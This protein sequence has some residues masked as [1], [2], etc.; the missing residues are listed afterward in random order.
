M[1]KLITMNAFYFYAIAIIGLL[2]HAVIRWTNNE[3]E[4]SISDWFLVNRKAS[5]NAF[6]LAMGGTIA[7]IL[8]GGITDP[9]DSANILAVWGVSYFMDSKFN[10]QKTLVKDVASGV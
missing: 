5:V 1:D 9:N 4:G 3:L 2:S 6:L 7:L 10:N 8:T